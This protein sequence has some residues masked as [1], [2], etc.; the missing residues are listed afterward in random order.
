MYVN[1]VVMIVLA[2]YVA[3]HVVSLNKSDL[4]G[5]MARLSDF[6]K[7]FSPKPLELN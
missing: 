2:V 6:D 7:S 4:V 1:S 3:L 5:P